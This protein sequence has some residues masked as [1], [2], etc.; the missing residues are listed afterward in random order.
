MPPTPRPASAVPAHASGAQPPPRL[1]S[2]G[3]WFEARRIAQ[4]LRRETVGGA[5]LLAAT[6]VALAWAAVGL[7]MNPMVDAG[8]PCAR[9]TALRFALVTGP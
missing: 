2:R 7:M 4:V 3:S 5:L 9:Q 6:V 1:F 8:A